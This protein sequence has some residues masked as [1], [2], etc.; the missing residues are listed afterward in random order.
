MRGMVALYVEV[1]ETTASIAGRSATLRFFGGQIAGCP[2]WVE[3]LPD[4]TFAPCLAFDLGQVLGNANSGGGVDVPLTGSLVWAAFEVIARIRANLGGPLFAEA[5]GSG[6]L[7]LSHSGFTFV[8]VHEPVYKIPIGFGS[9]G[10]G[11]GVHFP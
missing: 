1:P 3:F 10:L 11:I 6:G 8:G 7:T 9:L 5:V 2:L 4:V